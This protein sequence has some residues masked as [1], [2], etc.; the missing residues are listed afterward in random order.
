LT[1]AYTLFKAASAIVSVHF[2]N[3]DER[4]VAYLKDMAGSAYLVSRHQGLIEEAGRPEY[5]S[6][7]AMFAE[8]MNK[9]DPIHSQGYREGEEALTRVIEHYAEQDDAVV[10]HARALV[11]L[12]DWYM[13]FERRRAAEE[14][15]LLAYEKLVS[16]ED[17]AERITELFGKVVPLPAFSGA[18][19]EIA[20]QPVWQI[21]D[22]DS[23]RSGYADV[24]IDVN[25]FGQVSAVRVISEEN[26]ENERVMTMLR[27]HVRETTFRPVME[28]GELIRSQ[29]SRFRYRYRY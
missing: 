16:L 18:V 7:Q 25:S 22:A 27:R 24:S 26:A 4:Y 28:N 6:A 5:R 11:D 1:D 13:V 21:S 20:L 29:D 17:G 9:I 12:G 2:G 15:Y 8:R 3:D 19:G 10:A 14:Q 23:E